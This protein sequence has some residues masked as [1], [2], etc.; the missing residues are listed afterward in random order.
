MPK[1]KFNPRQL[2]ALK[3]YYGRLT[4]EQFKQCYGRFERCLASS[5]TTPKAKE[6]AAISKEAVDQIY[7]GENNDK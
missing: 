4:K 1:N 3:Q 5:I 7:A 2:A 6:R